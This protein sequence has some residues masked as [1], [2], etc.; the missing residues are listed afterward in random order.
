MC[1]KSSYF[2][3][4]VVLLMTQRAADIILNVIFSFQ[5]SLSWLLFPQSFVPKHYPILSMSEHIHVYGVLKPHPPTTTPISYR[6]HN[7]LLRKANWIN[8]LFKFFF[9]IFLHTSDI[10]K[11]PTVSDKF[12]DT[13]PLNLDVLVTEFGH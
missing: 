3:A 10:Q 8:F 9:A 2:G 5:V 1:A 13:C 12:E 11:P 4:V 7:Q 6:I